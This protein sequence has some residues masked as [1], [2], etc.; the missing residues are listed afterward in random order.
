MK[1][2]DPEAGTLFAVLRDRA[3]QPD[4]QD[5]IFR[6]FACFICTCFFYRKWEKPIKKKRQA[7]VTSFNEKNLL[8]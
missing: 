7:S 6:V 2:A 4:G 5:S 8:P 1:A 3:H